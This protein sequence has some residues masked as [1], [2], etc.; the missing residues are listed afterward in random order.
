MSQ[1]TFKLIVSALIALPLINSAV[2][3]DSIPWRYSAGNAE[4]FNNNSPSITS[5]IT[6]SGA[7]GVATGNSGIIIYNIT[8]TSG[9]SDVSPDAF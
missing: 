3:A 8:T 4:I 1:R 6:F 9:V 7:S 5:S 2:M